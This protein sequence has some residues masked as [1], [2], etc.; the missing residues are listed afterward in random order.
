MVINGGICVAWFVMNVWHIVV[1]KFERTV[2]RFLFIQCTFLS[3]VLGYCMC[4]LK[5]QSWVSSC[6]ALIFSITSTRNLLF[7]FVNLMKI[8]KT[9]L[10][11]HFTPILSCASVVGKLTRLI[12]RGQQMLQ[13]FVYFNKST[14]ATTLS[15]L[16]MLVIQSW[17]SLML[18]C[19]W[20]LS[21]SFYVS[22]ASASPWIL[23]PSTLTSLVC[24]GIV[25]L[26]FP[27][28]DSIDS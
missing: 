2:T 23:S 14:K 28:N 16:R 7:L 18:S 20:N 10:R 19:N 17:K 22:F 6:M 11:F 8:N 3:F 9:L 26:L 12:T 1:L 21:F 13:N 4:S 15:T 25:T 27:W 5:L 24:K